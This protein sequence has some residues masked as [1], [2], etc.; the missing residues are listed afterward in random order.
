MLTQGARSGPE[1]RRAYSFKLGLFCQSQGAAEGASTLYV[2]ESA[3]AAPPFRSNDCFDLLI[4]N[5]LLS[6]GRFTLDTFDFRFE[7]AS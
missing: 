4:G 5:D 2:F 1:R 3:F 6:T 7:F